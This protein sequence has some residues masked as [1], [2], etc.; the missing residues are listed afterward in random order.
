MVLLCLLTATLESLS[1][2]SLDLNQNLDKLE[3]ARS[4][5][6]LALAMAGDQSN[7]EDSSLSDS[8][9][10][11]VGEAPGECLALLSSS[12]TSPADQHMAS[13]T[14]PCEDT[15]NY[16]VLGHPGGEEMNWDD[17]ETQQEAT[18]TAQ[19]QQQ[20]RAC[21]EYYFKVTSVTRSDGEAATSAYSRCC[22]I[23]AD[24]R[25]TLE[26]FKKHLEVI[27]RVPAE[28]FKIFR[29]YPNSD[30]RVELPDGHAAIGEGR[31][32]L[33]RVLRKDEIKC[34]VYHLK[35]DCMDVNNFLFEHIIAKGQSVNA[36]KREI[37]F[38][39]KK[40]HML[41]IPYNKCRLR[42][43]G[44]KRPRKVYLDDQ[45][46]DK[47][48]VV[49]SNLDLF[50]QEL[51][52]VET[53]A[54]KD[55]LVL[56]VRRWCPSTLSLRPF[57]EVVL[58]NSTMEEL[59]R[60][61]SEKSGVPAENVDVAHIK[62]AFPCDM[63]L[64]DIQRTRLEPQRDEPGAV[65]FERRRWQRLLLQ[66]SILRFSFV[67]RVT[68]RY[69]AL[70]SPN[71]GE[72][73]RTGPSQVQKNAFHVLIVDSREA[74]KELTPDERKELNQKE[75]T[76]LGRLSIKSYSPGRERALKIYL[77]TS[78]SKSDENCID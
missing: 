78:P 48:I 13:P 28:Y 33:G 54:S 41:D 21:A 66:V 40:Q 2:P 20:Q 10:T 53:L 22:R 70:K 50:L 71:K 59:K 55:Q 39:A 5:R 1:I 43:K 6:S 30:G 67:E 51:S 58:D 9:R 65:A 61:I 56:F 35:P 52:D 62:A 17:E 46:F 24:K 63:H 37:L 47:D 26:R 3:L 75:N 77:D 49:T 16:D 57:Q 45:K 7:S 72:I 12:S 23:L 11:L 34:G 32:E 69:T 73:A 31:R 36:V 74:L 25:M 19:H 42:E 18:T 60:R 27:L 8:D 15:Y 14:D 4:P 76:R 44:W 38:Q 64:L 68:R 29:Q